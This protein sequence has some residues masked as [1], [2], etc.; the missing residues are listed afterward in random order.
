MVS[1][2]RRVPGP[3]AGPQWEAR[4]M[5]QPRISVITPSLNQGQYLERAICSVLD[6]GY[7]EIEY[8]V[9]DGG[10]T[11]GSRDILEQYNDQIAWWDSAPDGSP[12]AAINNALSHATGDVITILPADDILLPGALQE[13]AQIVE[14]ERKTVAWI[15]CACLR[16][17]ERD[18][19][20]GT[21]RPAEP[22]TLASFLMH[23][24]GRFLTA[25]TFLTR[26]L[27]DRMGPF[28]PAMRVAFDFEYW[29]RL[30]AA[31]VRP[32]LLAKTLAGRREHE[33]SLSATQTMGR[34]LEYI[35]VA[36]RYADHLPLAQR[37]ALWQNCDCR[38]RIYALAQA[39]M[40]GAE[41][42]GYLWQQ[43]VRHP[44]WFA[45][46]CV[47]HTLLHG[48]RAE[49]GGRPLGRSAA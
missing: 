5:S 17:G 44:W 23:N 6:Q 20:L 40:L 24:S 12:G 47:R 21:L 25:G 18:Q 15:A 41:A 43:L 42:R 36:R 46:D 14:E 38:Q 4:R 1:G 28:D 9:A 26:R 22:S 37:Y 39:E 48:V 11:D 2:T 29:S 27:L 8:L 49:L 16:L 3:G 31:G 19:M 13:V 10:S 7:E 35:A 45:D 32:R 34:G 33:G 30:M